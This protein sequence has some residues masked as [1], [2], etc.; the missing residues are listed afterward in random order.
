[1]PLFAVFLA[2]AATQTNGFDLARLKPS[3]V[4]CGS[5]A[6]AG[7][8]VVCARR[9]RHERVDNTPQATEPLLPRAEIEL[10]GN[11]RLGAEAEARNV[12]GFRSNAVMATVKIPF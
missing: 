10:P 2:Q 4:E 7:E 11:V 5:A 3:P 6:P 8:I 9:R 12:G 1:V